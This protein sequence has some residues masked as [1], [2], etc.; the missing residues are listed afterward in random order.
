MLNNEEIALSVE[1]LTKRFGDFVAVNSVSIKIST[2]QVYGILGPNGAGKSTLIKMITGLLRADA[3][4]V[5][6]FGKS[7]YSRSAVGLIGLCPQELVIWEGL[8]L[9]EQLLFIARMYNVPSDAAVKRALELLDAMGLS[10]KKNKLASTLSGGMKRRLNI[11]LA[12]MHDPRIL[13][14]DEPQ[15]GLDPQSRILVREYIKSIARKKTVIITTHDMEEA[16]KVIDRVAIIDRGKI[17]VDDTPYLLKKTVFQGELLEFTLSGSTVEDRGIFDSIKEEC[18]SV[19]ISGNVLRLVSSTPSDMIKPV[20]A[21]LNNL[22]IRIED[23][24]IRK[25]TLEDVFISLTGRGLRD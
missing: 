13:L 15:A 23:I 21:I 4:T 5:S 9:L 16:D 18:K 3:G 2:G 10:N 1:K 19:S 14:L 25:G 24:K 8:T 11:L 22:G 6:I 17:I 12:L 7:L 20:E